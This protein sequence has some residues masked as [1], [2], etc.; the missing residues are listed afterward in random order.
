MVLSLRHLIGL[1]TSLITKVDATNYGGSVTNK[2]S[3][4]SA[5]PAV[6]FNGTYGTGYNNNNIGSSEGS[7]VTVINFTPSISGASKVGHFSGN[8]GLYFTIHH[9]DGTTQKVDKAGVNAI[10]ET[11]VI[12]NSPYYKDRIPDW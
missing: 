4:A 11:S 7:V 6:L 12:S 2:H 5:D 1:E 9:E 3:A 8:D 10:T